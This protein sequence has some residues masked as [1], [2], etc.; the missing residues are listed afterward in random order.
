MASPIRPNGSGNQYNRGGHGFTAGLVQ[1]KTRGSALGASLKGDL[2]VS[3]PGEEVLLAFGKQFKLRRG[4]RVA[5]PIVRKLYE[6]LC[7]E[8]VCARRSPG[9]QLSK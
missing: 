1:N 9:R 3:R 8:A 2:F 5:R 7:E 4:G 6:G